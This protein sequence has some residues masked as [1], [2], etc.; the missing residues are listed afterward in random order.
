VP[1]ADR[2]P[3]LP[4]K[5]RARDTG[6]AGVLDIGAWYGESITS[7]W[8][9]HHN[10]LGGCKAL[11]G[12]LPDQEEIHMDQTWYTEMRFGFEVTMYIASR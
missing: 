8:G 2:Q 12:A 7:Q 5:A 11:P 10:R 6:L 4:K 1:A 3:L 9:L